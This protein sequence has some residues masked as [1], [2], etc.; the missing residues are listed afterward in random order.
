MGDEKGFDVT[1][2]SLL[3]GLT[4]AGSAGALFGVGS[5]AYL[6]DRERFPGNA[7]RAGT[8][9]VESEWLDGE[10]DVA[11]DFTGLTPGETRV[12]TAELSLSG[13]PAW[14]WFG[15]TC[16]SPERGIEDAVNVRL[17]VFPDCDGSGIDLFGDYVTLR[18]ALDATA[19]GSLLTDGPV[20]DGDAVCVE[21]R[22]TMPGDL[23]GVSPAVVAGDEI[24]VSFRF[25]AEQVRHNAS[26]VNPFADNACIEEQ[27]EDPECVCAPLGKYELDD[28]QLL[29][30]GDRL[31]LL[32][33]DEPTGYE[34][35]VTDVANKDEG[36][37]TG[38][39]GAQSDAETVGVVAT[40]DGPEDLLVC[41]VE[42][43]GGNRGDGEAVATYLVEPPATSTGLVS[44]T[45]GTAISHLVVWV[46]EEAI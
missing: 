26:L 12:G 36:D 29:A 25:V 7:V 24:D 13:N 4:A 27:E 19:G 40:L 42:V 39:N 15:S 3:V 14:V 6:Q 32:A 31:P 33:D 9:D 45:N 21:F 44:T 17:T 18:E 20:T 8:L 1:R 43:K 16:P 11:L 41:K 35:V 5:A 34:L 22:V 10:G 30:V 23:N 46:C 38:A 37:D 28:D 2:R